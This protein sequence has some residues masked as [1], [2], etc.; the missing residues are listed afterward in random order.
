MPIM[1]E[2]RPSVAQQVAHQIVRYIVYLLK[3]TTKN[4][5]A[6]Q[7]RF[8]ITAELNYSDYYYDKCFYWMLLTNLDLFGIVM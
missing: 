2:S 6:V 1:N 7:T 5:L 4:E 3:T 8:Q